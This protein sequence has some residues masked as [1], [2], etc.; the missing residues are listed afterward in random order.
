MRRK[1]WS[2]VLF[3]AA[4]LTGAPALAHRIFGI[5]MEFWPLPVTNLEWVNEPVCW[6]LAAV[7]MIAGAV[8][9]RAALT[10]DTRARA[11]QVR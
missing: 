9:G 7:L 4:L 5:R 2:E 1:T 11:G 8:V 10:R 3:T 6:T